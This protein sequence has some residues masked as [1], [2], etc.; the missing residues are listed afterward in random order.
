MTH[1]IHAF[2]QLA[3]SKNF[4]GKNPSIQIKRKEP[5][6]KTYET[7]K[8]MRKASIFGVYIFVFCMLASSHL[9]SFSVHL[10]KLKS[11]L[12]GNTMPSLSVI[13]CGVGSPVQFPL[14]PQNLKLITSLALV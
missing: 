10:T 4:L 14:L 11:A 8:N 7:L 9:D 12:C 1:L 13:L 3:T 5:Y 6:S 2:G